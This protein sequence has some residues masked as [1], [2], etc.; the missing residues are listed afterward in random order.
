M[1]QNKNNKAYWIV[2]GIAGATI[3]YLLW[4]KFIKKDENKILRD[5][6]DKIRFAFSD[7][8]SCIIFVLCFSEDGCARIIKLKSLRLLAQYC[9]KDVNSKKELRKPSGAKSMVIFLDFFLFFNFMVFLYLLEPI[10]LI[11]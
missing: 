8:H 1:A 6:L 2:G 5:E 7:K 11:L 10:T 3:L 9:A 4:R